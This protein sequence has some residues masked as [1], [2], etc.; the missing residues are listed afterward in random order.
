MLGLGLGLQRGVLLGGILPDFRNRVVADG[1]T[2]EAE[3]CLQTTISQ[4]QAQGLYDKASLIVTPNAY[5]AS[6][7]YSLKPTSGAGDLS[8][9]RAGVKRVRNASGNWVE[10]GVNVP[11]LHSS[12][13]GG[14]PSWLV[15]PQATNICL[16][17]SDLNSWS[18]GGGATVDNNIINSP[19]SGVMYD[20]LNLS[21]T[22][23]V[24][25][26][27]ISLAS[28]TT[29][30]LSCFVKNDTLIA[31]ENIRIVLNNNQ[32]SPNSL[33]ATINFNIV[34]GTATYSLGGTSGTGFSGVATGKVTP[35]I[36]GSFRIEITFTTGSGSLGSVAAIEFYSPQGAKS[37]FAT[38]PQLEIG[39]VATSPI[40]TAGSTVTRNADV[41]SRTGIAD[42]IGQTE[43]TISAKI[44]LTNFTTAASKGIMV[45]RNAGNTEAI[46]LL[47]LGNRFR[48]RTRSNSVLYT[49]FTTGSA[50]SFGNNTVTL[51]YS[52]TVF[53]VFINGV[54]VTTFVNST[55][56]PISIM[57]GVY[58][59][60]EGSNYLN[61]N[62]IKG[63]VY[64]TV[65]DDATAQ[66]LNL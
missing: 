12:V 62:F 45:L 51:V 2:I 20:R 9:A 26:G 52:A 37:Y 49:L 54:L 47:C 6:K 18:K 19:I 35:E 4:L 40:I 46:E 61:D 65:L 32:S 48:I 42:L 53:K 24:F 63:Y 60:N 25:R 10:I 44:N 55:A 21:N 15:E 30:T 16:F 13:G 23:Y 3:S 29:Y 64:K 14:C 58:L 41:I 57:D 59:G 36:D 11:P 50:F 38:A 33:I 31:G 22:A 17:N 5:K 34:A 56:I 43:G 1:G 7:I 27:S 8:F 28:N 66:S 39:S